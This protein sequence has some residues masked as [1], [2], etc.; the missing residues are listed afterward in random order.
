MHSVEPVT[1]EQAPS[2][3]K[4]GC[5][6]GAPLCEDPGSKGEPG[7]QLR[8]AVT[9]MGGYWRV[10]VFGDDFFK[11]WDC[12]DSAKLGGALSEAYAIVRGIAP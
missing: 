7:Q 11:T 3:Q 8:I 6:D 4:L 2:Q 10:D 12:A 9:S 5:D 1:E